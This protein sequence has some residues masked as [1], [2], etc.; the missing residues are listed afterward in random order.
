MLG[1]DIEHTTIRV[2]LGGQT[3]YFVTHCI[4]ARR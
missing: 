4:E 2:Q 1:P 3:L